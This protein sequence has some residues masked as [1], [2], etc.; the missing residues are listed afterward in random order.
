MSQSTTH[1]RTT[2]KSLIFLISHISSLSRDSIHPL[3]NIGDAQ[4][5]SVCVCV[6]GCYCL[7]T[8]CYTQQTLRTESSGW[9]N[10]S[11]WYKPNK[12]Y[13]D[14]LVRGTVQ[15]NLTHVSRMNLLSEL[16]SYWDFWNCYIITVS[17]GSKYPTTNHITHSFFLIFSV[18]YLSHLQ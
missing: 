11:S 17:F 1:W 7:E 3:E 18:L 4:E 15:H 10:V 8:V 16:V 13:R 6:S 2:G 9:A 5:W 12:G 14:L